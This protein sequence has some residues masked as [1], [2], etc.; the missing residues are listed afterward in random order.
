MDQVA[1]SPS[2]DRSQ[3]R[4]LFYNKEVRSVFFQIV[5]VLG[6]CALIAY[7][8]INM[9]TNLEAVGKELSFSFLGAPAG[10]DITC[11]LYTSPSPRDRH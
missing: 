10:Y 1:A 3:F 11:L 7:I 6:V 8:G 4:R 5:T 9:L 2:Q